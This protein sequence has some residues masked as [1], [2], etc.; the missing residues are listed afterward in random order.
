MAKTKDQV[1]DF[2]KKSGLQYV[3]GQQIADQLYLSRSAVWKAIKAL[4]KDGYEIAA[5]THR[6]YRLVQKAVLP[7]A[8][9]IRELLQTRWTDTRGFTH[10]LPEITVFESVG[11]TNDCAREYGEET[12][13]E[14]GTEKQGDKEK[15]DAEKIDEEKTGEASGNSSRKE[16][17]VIAGAQTGGRGRR[18][19]SFFSPEASGMYMSFLLY[20]Q[21]DF[22]RATR[23]TCMMAEAI[24]R[25]IDEITGIEIQIKWVNDIYC[26]GKKI[27]GILT[28]GRTSLE[29]GS[30][31]YVVIGAGINLCTPSGGFPAELKNIAGALLEEAPDDD[32]KNRLYAAVIDHFFR[33]YDDPDEQAYIEGYRRRSM[34]IGHYVKIMGY[35][36]DEKLPGNGY[37]LVTGIDDECRLQIRYD[38]G[39]TDAL[40]SGEVSV[41]KY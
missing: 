30:L 8:Q 16:R 38:N 15:T 40:S 18:G 20:P 26:R 23:L 10:P 4:R 7:D 28:E 29:D 33:L 22:A 13:Q 39:R 24:C 31:S 12:L 41:V 6:G 14:E 11:S 21:M 36:G 37:A 5:G 1:L 32:L 9:R 3:S 17:I 25:A 34:L 19:R 27:V 35:S 2:L